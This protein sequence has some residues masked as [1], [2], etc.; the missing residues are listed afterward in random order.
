M[1][2]PGAFQAKRILKTQFFFSL[3]IL[4]FALV[5]GHSVA[6]SA[7]IGAGTCLLANTLLAFWI[8][9][10]YRAAEK[11]RLAMRFYF[12]EAAK[13][14]LVIGSFAAAFALLDDL[15]IPVMLVVYFAVQVMPTLIATQFGNQNTK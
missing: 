14:T 7:F 15:D 2:Q 12:G 6:L 1:K 8:F 13:I 4:V 11:A 3:A 9:R 5:F 10:E